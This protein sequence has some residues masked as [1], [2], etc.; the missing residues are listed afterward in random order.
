MGCA[1]LTH[2]QLIII[3]DITFSFSRN[4]GTSVTRDSHYLYVL[5]HPLLHYPS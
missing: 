5:S 3:H 2:G 4:K 1:M